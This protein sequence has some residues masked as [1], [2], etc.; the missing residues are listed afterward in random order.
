MPVIANILVTEIQEYYAVTDSLSQHKIDEAM[1]HVKNVIF[2]EMFGFKVSTDI[3]AGTI[4]D[5]AGD[6]FM[7]F[8]KFVA[9]CIAAHFAR[10]VYIHTNAGVKAINQANWSTPTLADKNS[11]LM[12]LSDAV[13]AQFIEA[14]KIL[15]DQD[16]K[17]TDDYT[18]YSSFE[19]QKI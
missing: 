1:K 17:T 16:V 2:L 5:S 6:N 19:I 8:R 13:T 12:P 18:P 10:E 9:L 3:F 14:K 7:G 15:C 4:A 11:M